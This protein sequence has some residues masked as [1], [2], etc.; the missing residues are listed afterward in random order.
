MNS[1]HK[2]DFRCAD[3]KTETEAYVNRCYPCKVKWYASMEDFVYKV[4]HEDYE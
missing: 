3:C 1:K 2:A 4:D